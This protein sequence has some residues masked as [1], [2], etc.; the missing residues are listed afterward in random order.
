MDLNLCLFDVFA[1]V[2]ADLYDR[3]MQ[4]SL[5]PLLQEH[6]ALLQDFGV[7]VRP[8]IAGHRIYCLILFFDPYGE[9]RQ[10]P[11]TKRWVIPAAHEP[12]ISTLRAVEREVLPATPAGV[13]TS[14]AI[15]RTESGAGRFSPTPDFPS[16]L[17]LRSSSA[18]RPES[19]YRKRTGWFLWMCDN[20]QVL[21]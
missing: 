17:L 20:R 18:T 3:L 19:L 16:P 15:L 1:N 2:G 12:D 8:Q 6:F 4:F 7:N 10:H 9:G 21:F 11:S 14:I 5:H 13:A